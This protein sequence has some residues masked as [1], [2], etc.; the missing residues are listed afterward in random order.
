MYFCIIVL[1]LFKAVFTKDL[2]PSV[3]LLQFEKTIVKY[4]LTYYDDQTSLMLK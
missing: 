2:Y 4:I 1:D 3:K